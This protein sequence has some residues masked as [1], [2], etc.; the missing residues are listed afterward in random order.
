MSYRRFIIGRITPIILMLCLFSFTLFCENKETNGNDFLDTSTDTETSADSDDDA[1]TD[2]S[3]GGISDTDLDTQ[4]ESVVSTDADSDPSESLK[5]PI[6][7]AFYY[8]WYP[9]TWSVQGQHVFYHPDLGYYSSDSENVIERHINCLDYG[10]IDVAISSW[11]GSESYTDK[12]L[13]VLLNHT[14]ALG[15]NLK[16]AVY[17]EKE[18]F[19]HDTSVPALKSDLSYLK[20]YTGHKAFARVDGKPVVFVYNAND[21]SCEVAT[22]WAEANSQ[23]EWYVVLKVFS[24]Y[25][26][27]ADQPDAWH[28]YGPGTPA[29][30]H[31]PHSY[32]ISPGFWRADQQ[33][34]L[35]G[36]D[37]ARWYQNVRDMVASGERWHLIT[38]FNEWGEGTAIEPASEWKSDSG[39]GVYL[40]ALHTD[41]N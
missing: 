16:W 15:S 13:D 11:W 19:E 39:F 31:S 9:Q 30:R 14:V 21:S 24:G 32:G 28:Q 37:E 29:Q 12:R 5:F 35:L 36:R 4:T 40:D 38:T 25:R 20:K 3:T 41:G 22:R 33:N 34:P 1:D 6:R 7:A 2:V 23:N 17:Y 8:P 18:G 26:D 27:C 10:K